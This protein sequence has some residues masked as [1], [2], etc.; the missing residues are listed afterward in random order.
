[1]QVGQFDAEDNSKLYYDCWPSGWDD[2]CVIYMHGLES[3]MGWFSNL[4]EYLSS[5]DINVYAFDR[6]GSGLNKNNSR[7]FSSRYLSS[8][9]K[10][11]IDLVKKEHP[12]STIFL[13]GLCL[14]GKL[15]VDFF[16][17]HRDCLDGLI[18]IS[19]SLKS[20]LKFSLSD[21][22]SIL[23][24][25]NSILKVP[26]KGSM[27][28]SNEKWLKFIE[29]DSLRLKHIPAL[30][31]L[32]IAKMGRRLKEASGNIKLPVLLM[33]AGV[34]DIIDTAA[35]RIWFEKLP[36]RDKVL[37]FYKDYHHLLTFEKEA[38]RVMEDI[39]IWIKKRAYA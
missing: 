26:I 17:Y 37:K 25:P 11:F 32:E 8:D 2:P 19:P 20:K 36:S 29:K 4:A 39:V 28:T 13:I 21:K 24:R 16:S 9:L 6:R 30:H 22:L 27:F 33:L 14:G 15:A 23:F 34:D 10:I 7:N 38:D 1:M 18:L 31:L 12:S 35:V 5:N 3:H